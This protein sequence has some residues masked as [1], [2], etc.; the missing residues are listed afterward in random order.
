MEELLKELTVEMIPDNIWRKVAREI[1]PE[2]LCK[3]LRLV[4]GATIYI[5]KLESIL[6]PIRDEHIKAEFNGWNYLE[7]AQ[8]YNLTDRAVREICGPGVTE[9][10]IN[11]FDSQ[12]EAS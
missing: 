1:G 10:Q 9:E 2:N 6:R 3:M 4:G 11:F 5:P 8:K 7:L 12:E